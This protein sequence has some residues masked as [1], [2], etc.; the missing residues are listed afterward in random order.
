[1]YNV[2]DAVVDPAEING[3][4]GYAAP[5]IWLPLRI[6]VSHRALKPHEGYE[7]IAVSGQLLADGKPFGRSLPVPM[8]FTIQPR[9]SE[10]K[11]QYH[12]LEFAMD[13][14][15]IAALDKLRA[16]G[17]LRLRLEVQLEVL[18]LHALNPTPPGQPLVETIW[19]HVMRHRLQANTDLVVPRDA[20]ISRVLP[21]VGFGVIHLIELPALSID[22]NA[23][24]AHA[25]EALR[26]AQALH[27]EGRYADAV[28]KCRVALEEFFESS[29]V[30]GKD[31]ITRRVPKLKASWETKLGRA[32]YDW[33]NASLAAL[34]AGTNKPHHL[35]SAT[36]SQFDSQMLQMITT[37]VVSYATRHESPAAVK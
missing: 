33:L 10:L 5:Q 13:N 12:G 17:D 1:M 32:T 30:K 18:Q 23:V 24:H 3:V 29:E 31:D 7:F 15:R 20:W 26:Q 25:F 4:G 27:R 22:Q 36:Y 37:A 16:G 8:G 14:E 35:A 34:K 2:V 28:G 19:G 6:H 21:G 9:F 11:N